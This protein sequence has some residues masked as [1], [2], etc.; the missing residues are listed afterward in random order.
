MPIETPPLAAAEPGRPITAEGWNGIVD[1]LTALYG[2]VASFG[3]GLL[4]VTV[5]AAGAP[6][7]GARVV[8][9]PTG[10]GQPVLA[11]PPS[12]TRTSHLVTG[13]SEGT[14]QIQVD[15]PGF[16][17]AEATATVPSTTPLVVELVPVG[18]V[19]P[20]VF[21]QPLQ[22]A[23]GTLTNAGHGI[24]LILD[25]FGKEVA[26]TPIPTEYQN[27]PVLAQLPA[28]GTRLA[29]TGRVQLVV[30]TTVSQAPI[31]TMPNLAG[32]TQDEAIRVL[33]QLGLRV[34][35]IQVVST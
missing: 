6:V 30:A 25:A 1:A 15:A 16:A 20:D 26:R 4:E 2:I 18:P 5:T 3:S 8:A 9:V 33:D 24:G 19:V 31:V 23:F 22:S 32:L 10:D 29:P 11:V 13:V 14:W 35:R 17:P 34:G 7:V 12:G 27:V 28:A 21:G